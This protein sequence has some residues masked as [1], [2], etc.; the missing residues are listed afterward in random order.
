MGFPS[1]AVDP[2]I[3]PQS[4]ESGHPTRAGA[5]SILTQAGKATNRIRHLHHP[6]GRKKK[7]HTISFSK[8]VIKHQNIL[9][10]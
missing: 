9:Q 5:I 2:E 7:R 3:G 1:S 4:A 10:L 8:F 6:P